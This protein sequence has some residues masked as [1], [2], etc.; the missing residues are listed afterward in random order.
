MSV[1]Q[2]KITGLLEKTKHYDA[3][4][5]FMAVQDLVNEIKSLQSVDPSLQVPVRNAILSLL[6]DKSPN[7]STIAVKCLSQL[8]Q[9]FATEQV[10]FIVDRLGS[11]CV[12]DT[13]NESRDVVADGLKSV[14]SA[15]SEANGK[16]A[17]SGLSGHLVRGLQSSKK[18]ARDFGNEMVLLDV[19]K[20]LLERYGS[21]LLLTDTAAISQVLGQLL[22]HPAEPVRKRASVTLGPLVLVLSDADFVSLVKLLMERLKTSNTP[23]TY[24]QSI[25]VLTRHA[26]VR[27]GQDLPQIMPT[28]FSYL[29][30]DAATSQKEEDEKEVELWENCLQA[31]E[32]VIRQCPAKV[33]PYVPTILP[34]A[35]A[36]LC[37]DPTKAKRRR[38]RRK[39]RRTQTRTRA[40]AGMMKD[41][42]R[43]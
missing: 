29:S 17:A 31:L 24:V 35:K 9:M 8:V 32:S 38:E 30:I 16:L 42:V 5:R 28:L 23:E 39:A 22:E 12:D 13:K 14:M 41:G 37:W 36:Y 43:L 3:D 1:N 21:D 2:K 40:L 7:V 10:T 26:G 6:D 33:S 4:E 15:I 27:I 19:L 18:D 25:S 34:L 11:F 20:D